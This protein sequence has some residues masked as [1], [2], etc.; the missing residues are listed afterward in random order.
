MEL[1]ENERM[2]DLQLGGY[3][4]LQNSTLFCFSVDAVLLAHFATVRKGDKVC[5]L[6]SGNGIIPIL[7]CANRPVGHVTGV[8]LL[9]SSWDLAVRSMELNGLSDRVEMLHLDLKEAPEK[10]G[11]KTF[12]LVT[13]NPPFKEAGGGIPSGKEELY[14][15]RHEV[16]CTLEDII[17]SSA[18][19]LNDRGRL[20]M[21]HRPER[22][23]DIICLM[24]KYRIEPKR[25]RFVHPTAEKA[26]TMVLVEGLKY[27]K[28]KVLVEPPLYVHDGQGGY[29]QE[30]RRIYR[31]DEF[32]KEE[33]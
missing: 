25:L 32:E 26:P 15:A 27:G 31:R 30:I 12:D 10:L 3:R 5:D 22:L 9:F 6:C 21:V 4:I 2:D 18:A 13:C 16:A 23:C 33:R 8:E 24:R 20:A 11:S 29:T 17:A 7:L 19:L 1:R 28:P 14:I